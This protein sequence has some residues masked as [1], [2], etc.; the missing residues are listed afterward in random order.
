MPAVFTG[1]E[2]LKID[3]AMLLLLLLLLLFQ[4]RTIPGNQKKL[5]KLGKGGAH[6]RSMAR[7]FG[8]EKKN[9]RKKM[10]KKNRKAKINKMA[11]GRGFFFVF[12][13]FFNGD[14]S[15]PSFD[16]VDDGILLLLSLAL[17]HFSSFCFGCVSLDYRSYELRRETLKTAA[18]GLSLWNC[19]P[20]NFLNG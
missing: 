17:L 6:L 4:E 2:N 7:R 11:A 9:K 16:A 14:G 18:D 13:F 12:W 8:F 10:K 5:L 15:S 3:A 1:D 19:R 20:Y